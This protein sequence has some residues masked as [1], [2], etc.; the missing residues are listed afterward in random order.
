M[1]CPRRPALGGHSAFLLEGQDQNQIALER[2]YVAT[3]ALTAKQ[4]ED[5]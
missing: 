1:G 4:V 3:E 2:R 5:F